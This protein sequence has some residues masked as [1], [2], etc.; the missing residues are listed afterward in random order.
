MQ[1]RT[2]GGARDSRD[3]EKFTPL[4]FAAAGLHRDQIGALPIRRALVSAAYINT[5]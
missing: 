1:G 2:G 4:S 5:T 3:S